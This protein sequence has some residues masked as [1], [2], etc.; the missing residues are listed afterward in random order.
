MAVPAP[1][2]AEIESVPHCTVPST[3]DAP[4]TESVQAPAQKTEPSSQWVTDDPLIA[5]WPVLPGASQ[6]SVFQQARSPVGHHDATAQ[7]LSPAGADEQ[8]AANH[9]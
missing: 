5:I 4:L 9:V 8:G 1:E 2:P 3:L 6:M 7:L